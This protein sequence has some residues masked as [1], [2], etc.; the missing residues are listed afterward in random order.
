MKKKGKTPYASDVPSE[1][2]VL[3]Q[4][5]RGY[6][7]GGS[8][9]NIDTGVENSKSSLLVQF[10]QTR[11]ALTSAQGK[12]A[13]LERDIE[14]EKALKKTAEAELEEL[15]KQLEATQQLIMENEKL[16]KQLEQSREPYEKKI[17]ELTLEL[18]KAQI[19][20]TKA[21]QELISLKIEQLVEKK[22]QKSQNFQ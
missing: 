8:T 9:V 6:L 18:T 22:K 12:I 10:D 21:R 19:E 15:N 14:S 16:N 1:E 17:K 4:K 7:A 5:S 20:E 2:I 13:L 11:E 3:P